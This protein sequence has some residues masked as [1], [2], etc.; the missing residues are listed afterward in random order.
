[1]KIAP[2]Q[3][4]AGAVKPC[5][6]SFALRMEA[7]CGFSNPGAGRAAD[8]SDYGCI[9]NPISLIVWHHGP[10]CGPNLW[11]GASEITDYLKN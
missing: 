3:Y 9:I 7:R 10:V 4:P 11:G 6:E 8:Y 2:H 5:D 1:M